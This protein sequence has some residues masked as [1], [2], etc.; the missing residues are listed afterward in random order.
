MTNILV[1]D[2]KLYVKTEFN[3]S[4]VQFMRSRPK[5]F[6][7]KDAREWEI[8][9]GEL[10]N[11]LAVLSNI[12]L[13]YDIKYSN[14]ENTDAIPDWYNFKIKP[15]P[16]QIE[17]VEYGLCHNKF[18]LADE[19]G[20]GK[21]KQCLDLS[22]IRKKSNNIKHVLI[23]ACVN[24]LKYN[25]YDEVHKHTD[26][27]AYI[28]GTRIRK[29]LNTYIGSN[30]DRLIDIKSIGNNPDIDKC[31]Y[32]I[33][34]IETLR[35]S[36]SEII[37]PKTKRGKPR[38]V[39]KFPIVEALQ[40]KIEDGEIGMIIC[41]EMH[42]LKNHNSQSCKAL[43]SLDCDYKVALT[44]TPVMSKP[45]DVYSILHWLGEEQHSHFSFEK[46]Y[47]IKGDFNQI[48]G[49]K[50]LT[51][52]QTIL[53]RCMLRRKKDEVLDLPEK[54][55]VNDY[56]EMT[57]PQKTIYNEILENLRENVDK[58]KLSPNPLAQFIRLRQATGNPEI[59]STTVKNSVKYDRVLQIL[60][61]VVANDDKMIIFSNWTD[62]L[63]PL[64]EILKKEKYYPALYT[65]KNT[66]V[67]NAEKD[68]FMSDPKC[69][70][71]L[72]TSAMGTGLTLTAASTVVFLD[73]PWTR[74]EKDQWEDRAHRIG[75]TKPVTIITIMCKGT[76][77][78][79]VND[80]V[81][82][83]GKMSDILID[84]EEDI[85]KNPNIVKYLL[86]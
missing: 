70:V 81:Y 25:W 65:G 2:G 68:R 53:D 42:K 26:D 7:N 57:K 19:Q 3:P 43:T 35:Y 13:E 41:D 54:I 24:G 56:V 36:K 34:N 23:V 76:I 72:G 12:D 44:G 1:R 66:D 32:I 45:I 20:L 30:E 33:T 50:N 29:N 11:L 85:Y 51:D 31:F 21:T 52:L 63:D 83:K 80:I 8:P 38:K 84:K 69:K 40:E 82:K 39:T 17:G 64:Y 58:I 74:A 75:T 67:R 4:I 62:V 47:C 73:E 5:R 6:W 71:I 15:F 37:E 16:H 55:Y 9:E 28:L 59:L 22:Q 78:E 77:D 79:K 10:E 18:L 46:H 60:E 61:D 48:V 14:N 49:Y 86:S 27:G